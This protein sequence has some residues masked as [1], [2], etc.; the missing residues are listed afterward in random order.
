MDSILFIEPIIPS[1]AEPYCWV[2]PRPDYFLVFS[3]LAILDLILQDRLGHKV[4][5]MICGHCN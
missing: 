1:G 5:S 4:G 3:N 2:K